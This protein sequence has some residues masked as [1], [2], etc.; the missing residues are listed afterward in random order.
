MTSFSHLARRALTS[1]SNRIPREP[2]N[3]ESLLNSDEIRLW[4]SM[5]GRDQTHSI[6]VLSRFE[7]LCPE[8]T[9]SERAAALLH[10]LGKTRS[11]LGWLMRII[12]TVVGSRGLRFSEYHDHERIGAEML[13]NISDPRTIDLVGGLTDDPV[14][15]LLRKADEI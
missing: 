3:I 2:G 12:A 14:A 11:G 9:R 15:G 7:G 8:A 13:M 6:V 1:W 4:R 10:D 5:P